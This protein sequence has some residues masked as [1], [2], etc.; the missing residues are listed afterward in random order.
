MFQHIAFVSEVILVRTMTKAL[1]TVTGDFLR[2][3]W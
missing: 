1:A 3:H 2:F